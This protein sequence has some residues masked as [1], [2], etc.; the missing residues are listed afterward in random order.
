MAKGGTL[1]TRPTHFV[2]AGHLD[3]AAKED[4]NV[5]MKSHEEYNST[6]IA[7]LA[8]G[9]AA[10]MNIDNI[11]PIEEPQ[12]L[13]RFAFGGGA[14]R[15]VLYH[16]SALGS[17][18]CAHFA[19]HM[20][21]VKDAAPMRMDWVVPYPAKAMGSLRALY[22]GVAEP[23][24]D[25]RTLF[26]A[27][28]GKRRCAMVISRHHGLKV[29]MPHVEVYRCATDTA[30]VRQAI[31]LLKQDCYDLVAVCVCGF[32]SMMQATPLYGKQCERSFATHMQEFA[33]LCDAAGVYSGVNTLVGFCPDYGA[34]KGFLCGKHN[35]HYPA[36][37]NVT[38][39]FG[40]V[41]GLKRPDV[42]DPTQPAPHAED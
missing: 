38:H 27:C 36:D 29:D 21:G 35:R 42:A 15:V 30:T 2:V 26:D 20:E 5:G 9:L 8:N 19:E 16:P 7:Q 13:V 12:D 37:L 18:V 3:F 4:Y 10:V 40:V 32:D 1:Y 11:G 41:E 33:L 39:Y 34:H 24:K 25:Q 23:T 22:S 31:A 28:A 6:S 17:T 14:E